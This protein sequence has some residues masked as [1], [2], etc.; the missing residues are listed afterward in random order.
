M[1]LQLDDHTAVLSGS[2]TVSDAEPLANWL[3]QTPG[4]AVD[5][6]ACTHLHTAALQALASARPRI[7]VT[8]TDAFLSAWIVPLLAP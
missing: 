4:G 2:I 5:L 7:S 8:P 3:R 6:G 1:P